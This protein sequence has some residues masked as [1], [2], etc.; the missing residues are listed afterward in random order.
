M[1]K[2]ALKVKKVTRVI[3]EKEAYKVFKVSKDSA[4]LKVKKVIREIK[5]KEALMVEMEGMAEME[6]FHLTI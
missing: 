4:A 6:L 5:V 3:E 2:M 1:E